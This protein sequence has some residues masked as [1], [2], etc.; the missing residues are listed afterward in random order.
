M[1]RLIP[2]LIMSAVITACNNTGGDNTSGSGNADSAS[3]PLFSESTLP[4]K[5]IPFDKIKEEHFMPAF[6]EG[7]KQHTAEIEKIANDSA[8]TT[9]ENTLAALEAA[10][11]LLNR[12]SRAF[13]ALTSANTNDNL[14]KMQEELA[15]K[16][17]AHSDALYLNEKIFKKIDTLYRQRERLNLEP[18]AKRLVEFYRDRFVMRGANLSDSNKIKLKKLNEEEALLTTKF[19]N[20]LLTA[21]KAA[22]VVIDTKEELDGL[23]EAEIT[24]AG[25]AAKEAKH[26]GKYLLKI[27]NTTQQPMLQNLNNR[28][29]RKKLYEA[30]VTR[31]EKG[32]SNDTRGLV[33]RLAKIRTEKA[34]LLGFPNFAAWKLQDQVARNPQAVQ[35]MF[36]KLVPAAT[37]KATLEAEE[38]K[39]FKAQQNDTTAL[40]PWDWNYYAEKLR[41]AKYDLDENQIK[42][43]FVVDSVLENGVFYA[44]TRLYGITFKRRS[45]IPV[46][47]PDV[48]VYE[49]FDA[50]ST[51]MAL[52]YIDYFKRDNKRGGAWM[53]NFVGQS[54]L[55]GTKPVIVNVCNYTKPADG[56]PALVSWDEVTTLFH[57]FGHTLH[58]LFASQTYPSLSGTAVARDFVELPSQFNEHWAL[59]SAVL[60]NYA[61]HHKTGEVMPQ[62]LID[63][64]KNASTFNQGYSFTEILA[65]SNLD[66]QW[67]TLTAKDS[68][69]TDV[70]AFE[71]AA[72]ERTKL[73]MPYVP[74]RYKSSYFQHIWAGGYSA[75]YYAYT[76]AEMLDNDAY[77]WFK[78]NGGLTRENGQRFRD[79]ILSKGNTEDLAKM[80]REFRGKDPS[81]TPLL[82]NRGLIPS[83]PATITAKN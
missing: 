27:L 2:I 4:Y 34:N 81:I 40:E 13:G 54:K 37:V 7:M 31:A 21:S 65:A 58:G 79:M 17:S 72:L 63:K 57:E 33:L 48:K 49:I 29:T 70:E 50:D 35:A 47:H 41:K 19:G 5:A 32:D 43:Y 22:A 73:W 77:A 69:V 26:E 10:G 56:E 12:A 38:L 64:I 82:E 30:S 78:E 51:P 74:P 44:A 25:K 8:A 52:F 18:E 59:D 11:Q 61:K 15:P 39:A 6:E 16:L 28:E 55:L 20:Q 67:H 76:W 36:A 75:S 68:A 24:A 1:K 60:K 23:T 45:D 83:Q 71:K 80:Y 9:F 53:N 66:M 46:Y 3:N 42:P 62:D 14:K